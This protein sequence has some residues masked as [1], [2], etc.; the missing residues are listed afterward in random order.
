MTYNLYINTPLFYFKIKTQ[1]RHKNGNNINAAPPNN[2]SIANK[3]IISSLIAES[4]LPGKAFCDTFTNSINI[5]MTIGKP[6]IAIKL[7]LLSAFEEIAEINVNVIENPK[8]AKN[9]ATKN[10]CKSRTGLPKTKLNTP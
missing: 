4:K 1:S 5:G 7:A 6:K 9:I 10:N 8:L 3:I 2:K